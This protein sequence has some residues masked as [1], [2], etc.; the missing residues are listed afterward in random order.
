MKYKF[1]NEEIKNEDDKH[2]LLDYLVAEYLKLKE[3]Y[4]KLVQD[5]KMK[6]KL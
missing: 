5:K 4:I 6:N 2:L 3:D 1:E